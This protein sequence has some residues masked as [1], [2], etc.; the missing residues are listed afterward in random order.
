MDHI[1]CYLLKHR[2]DGPCTP[3]AEY[4]PEEDGER[5]RLK[6]VTG[7]VGQW[8][9]I[10]KYHNTYNHARICFV[11]SEIYSWAKNNGE[12]YITSLADAQGTAG[13]T[14]VT[15]AQRMAARAG[16][17]FVTKAHDN[18]DRQC[19]SMYH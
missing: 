9:N 12:I 17:A 2:R 10:F 7:T 11:W 18:T 6:C 8:V 5:Q 16:S 4:Q 3:E 13:S 19:F 1:N 14:L 15:T